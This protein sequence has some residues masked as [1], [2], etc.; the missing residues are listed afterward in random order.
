MEKKRRKLTAEQAKRISTIV[1]VVYLIIAV[2]VGIV[3]RNSE[4]LYY[5]CVCFTVSLTIWTLMYIV[6][7]GG[8]KKEKEEKNR[9]IGAELA[10]ILSRTEFKEVHFQMTPTDS[11]II[12]LLDILEKEQ[13][14]FY[15]KLDENKDIIIKCVDKHGD[16]V[17]LCRTSNFLYFK[18]FFKVS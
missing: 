13:V 14:T 12:M 8:A 18:K 3:S 17:H 2:I 15:A 10:N 4:K 1:S 7:L 9:Q 6:I 5:I 11:A 16:V